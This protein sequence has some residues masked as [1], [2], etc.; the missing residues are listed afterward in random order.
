VAMR[1]MRDLPAMI[2]RR[3]LTTRD[4]TPASACPTST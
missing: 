1:V 3:R 4:P 2:E